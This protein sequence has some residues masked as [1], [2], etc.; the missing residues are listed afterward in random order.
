MKGEPFVLRHYAFL[1]V[2]YTWY[3]RMIEL[4]ETNDSYELQI[5]FGWWCMMVQGNRSAL[6]FSFDYRFEIRLF[7]IYEM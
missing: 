1:K 3:L 7:G 4:I 5:R 2:F 6:V